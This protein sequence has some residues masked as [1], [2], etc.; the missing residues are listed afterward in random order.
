MEEKQI[1]IN[2]I[3][4]NYRVAGKGLVVLIL[5]G[6]GSNSE[7]WERVIGD[8]SNNNFKV[9]VPDLPGFGKSQEPS[10]VWGVEEYCSFVKNLVNSLGL[11]KFVLLGHSFGGAL[12]VK[13]ASKLPEKIDKLLLVGAACFRRKSPRKKLFYVFAKI[14]KVFSF[15]PSYEKIR[16]GFYKIVVRRS[17][18]PYTK[19]IMK[20]IYLK[21]IK[22]DLSEELSQIR[23]PTLIIWGKKD[24][25]KPL[26]EAYLIKEKIKDARLAILPEAGHS[27]YRESPSDFSKT[28]LKFLK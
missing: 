6:W 12:A 3:K 14:L 24:K 27:P 26:K 8:L 2:G 4:T 28:I 5:H 7:K 20:D 17:D 18:Y 16:K 11:E 22:K 10:E 13:Y 15:L 21:V 19:G 1:T 23:I 9:I 25:I